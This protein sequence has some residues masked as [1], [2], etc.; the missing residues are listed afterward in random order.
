MAAEHALFCMHELEHVVIHALK[1]AAVAPHNPLTAAV[2]APLKQA[3]NFKSTDA[4][5]RHI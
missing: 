4:Q 2:P 3:N 5:T 1:H